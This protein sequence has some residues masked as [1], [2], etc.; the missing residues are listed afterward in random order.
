[1]QGGSGLGNS[2]GRGPKPAHAAASIQWW[3]GGLGQ[4]G[5]TPPRLRQPGP[6]CPAEVRQRDQAQGTEGK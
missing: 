6:E 5:H 3:E 4:Q 1:M 2:P